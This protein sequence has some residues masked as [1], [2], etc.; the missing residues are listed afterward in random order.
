M[1]KSIYNNEISLS[2]NYHLIY[3]T[4][5]NSFLVVKNT[6]Y[7][8]YLSL[9]VSEIFNEYPS[10]YNQLLQAGIFVE[11]EE[12]EFEKLKQRISKIDDSLEQYT[13]TINPT[14][15]CNFNC[16]YC[17]E[18]HM[19]HSKMSF[20][21]LEYVKRY[22]TK[23][24]S[25]KSLKRFNL[26]F[27]GG[28]PLLYYKDIVHPL[29]KHFQ[30]TCLTL[31]ISS[32][33]GFTSNGY[34]LTSS[35]IEDLKSFGVSSFQITL[36]GSKTLHN[37][38]RYPF[39]GADS[40]SKI[41][42]NINIFVVLRINYTSDN[43]ESTKEIIN[44]LKDIPNN[45]KKNIHVDFQRVWQDK[46]INDLILSDT[47]VECIE[48]FESIGIKVYGEIINQ[49]WN[50]CYADKVN[51][52]VINFNRDVFKCT[53]RDFTKENRLG[54][55][56]EDGTIIWDK[57]KMKQREGVRLSKEV[58]QHCRI[59]PICG[60]TC[61]QRGLDSGNSNLCIRGLNESG[62]DNIVLNQFYYNIV[63]N[64]VSV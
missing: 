17:Y 7:N 4:Y 14:I 30:S 15:N 40:Y 10:F 13:L 12:C 64:G 55:L 47:L 31:G 46:G 18:N 45:E 26:S 43:L 38:V 32:S 56:N 34:L 22:I 1:K 51:Q 19:A 54:V 59:A 60:G 9:S 41:V 16:W 44:D 27:F 50:S 42:S 6:L 11:D 5:T 36:D 24:C 58:C 28:E 2:P 23:I 21:T 63:K 3:N 39:E 48:A 37:K 61:T 35:M 49:V 25:Q 62:K 52:A 53:A 8:K 57:E 29:L 20:E 33:I